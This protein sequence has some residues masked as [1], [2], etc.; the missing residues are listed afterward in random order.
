M[1]LSVEPQLTTVH[2]GVHP[3]G[4]RPWRV[5]LDPGLAT[6][7]PAPDSYRL[8]DFRAGSVK[9][10]RSAQP[11]PEALLTLDRLVWS[12]EHLINLSV[13]LQARGVDLVALGQGIDTSTAAGRMFFQ[14]LGAAREAADS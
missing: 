5:S 9:G 3:G 6:P 10:R 7:A 11:T 2:T 12:L 1:T 8:R 13:D 4:C 14:I